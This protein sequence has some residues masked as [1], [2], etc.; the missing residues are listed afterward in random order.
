MHAKAPIPILRIFDEA[1]AKEFYVG[2]L[3]FKIDW[4]HQYGENFPI[5][6]QV[7]LDLCVLHLSEH[8]GDGCPGSCLRIETA[9]LE[10]FCTVLRAKDYKNFKPGLPQAMPW[11]T[12]EIRVPDPFGNT[13][14]FYERQP[15]T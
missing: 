10:D 2:F 5:Y 3:G 6:V 9:E 15:A 14:I 4:E 7:S 1:K 11:G 12:N 8:H 13:L